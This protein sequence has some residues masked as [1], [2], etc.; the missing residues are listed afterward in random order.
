MDDI[1]TF[2][3]SATE[4]TEEEK[5]ELILSYISTRDELN[6]AEQSN[7]LD[8]RN[9][10]FKGKK[11]VLDEQFLKTLH[12]KMFNEVWKWSGQ[13][14]KTQKNIG[15][16]TYRISMELNSLISDI[17]FWIENKTFA[18]EEI[19]ARLHHKL[20]W[21][22]PFVNGNGKFSRLVTDIFLKSNGRNFFNWG[23]NLAHPTLRRK[24]YIKSLKE[25]DAHNIEP[26]L[27]FLK[28][29]SHAD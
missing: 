22:H 11:N 18:I 15:I 20:V 25:A 9:W 17:N 29:D 28:G 13:Y 16:E 7:I 19:A 4:L 14:R 1:F 2:D 27:K 6:D 10:A 12:K 24:Q 8:A 21:I 23:Y 5:E 26:L 3:D